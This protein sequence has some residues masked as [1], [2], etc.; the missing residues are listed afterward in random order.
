MYGPTLYWVT[1]AAVMPWGNGGAGSDLTE[2][3]SFSRF[4]VAAALPPG[5]S[6]ASSYYGSRAS[7]NWSGGITVLNERASPRLAL[8][9]LA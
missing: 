5:T 4:R 7:V 9:R 6:G 2:L 1:G 3:P 8:M